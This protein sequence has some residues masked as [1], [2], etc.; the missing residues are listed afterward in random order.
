MSEI[1][2]KNAVKREAGYLYYIDK[3]GNV[4]RSEMGRKK[5]EKKKD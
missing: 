2:L 5:K 1:V 3:D 4:C